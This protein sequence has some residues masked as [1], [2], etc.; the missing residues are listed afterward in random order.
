MKFEELERREMLAA[1]EGFWPFPTCPVVPYE[2]PVPDI[3]GDLHPDVNQK[4]LELYRIANNE[5]MLDDLL[6]YL[7]GVRD[8]YHDE[9]LFD[10]GV[11]EFEG[12]DIWGG[13]GNWAELALVYFIH[14][15]AFDDSRF[16]FALVGMQATL[17]GPQHV[18]IR[19]EYHDHTDL[20][21]NFSI[22]FDN[23]Y[24]DFRYNLGQLQ[25]WQQNVF[26]PIFLG[27]HKPHNVE[28]RPHDHMFYRHDT[29]NRPWFNHV[30]TIATRTAIIEEL[31]Q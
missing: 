27:V 5:P 20:N 17:G 1:V 28:P 11:P 22:Y 4:L 9:L 16:R 26:A 18:A 25:L 30:L 2:P 10:P 24:V 14:A 23:N 8:Y 29:L 19:V 15:D 21:L 3:Q 31:A 12:E 6:N 13:C 7:H